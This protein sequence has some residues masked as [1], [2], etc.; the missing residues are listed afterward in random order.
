VAGLAIVREP[1]EVMGGSVEVENLPALW[2][3]LRR[4]PAELS[5]TLRD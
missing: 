3:P 5:D 1:A 4:S 2:H